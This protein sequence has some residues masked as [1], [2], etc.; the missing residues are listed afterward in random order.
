MY[1]GV[2]EF[3]LYSD[4]RELTNDF[5]RSYKIGILEENEIQGMECQDSILALLVRKEESVKELQGWNRGDGFWRG[6]GDR[7]INTQ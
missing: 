6:L 1:C 2:K 5:K 4:I 3:G 7:I